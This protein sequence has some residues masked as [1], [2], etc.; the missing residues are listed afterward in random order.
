MFFSFILVAAST[1]RSNVG[2]GCRRDYTSEFTATNETF[3]SKEELIKWAKEVGRSN[4][5]TVIVLRSDSGN[6]KKKPR[7][8]LGC[9]RSGKCDI[10]NTRVKTTT[11]KY[12]RRHRGT[13]KC[14][15]PFRLMGKKLDAGDEWKLIVVKGK[16][17]H[18]A[19]HPGKGH[20]FQGRLFQE[21]K[22][23]MEDLRKTRK[24]PKE[25]VRAVQE[26]DKH[27]RSTPRTIYNA[28]QRLKRIQW[29]EH[30]SS[31]L[32]E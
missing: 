16:H 25:I 4:D 23:V 15:C 18:E 6:G 27:N 14:G 10:R 1:S 29:C 20:S 17:N 11:D 30:Y 3:K 9:E 21:E 8:T 31:G 19:G 5:T 24:R 32:Q 13:K 2:N 7:V 26:M 28:C 22:S 12:G